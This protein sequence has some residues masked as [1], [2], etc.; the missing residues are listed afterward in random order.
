MPT[1]LRFRC[2]L[3]LFCAAVPC[4]QAADAPSGEQIYRKQC[5]S[6]H[7]DKGEGTK[8]FY[9]RPLEGDHSVA[10]LAKLIGKTMPKDDPGTCPD[11]DKVAAFVFDSFYSKAARERNQRP[12][13]ELSRLTVGQHQH[14]I[15]DLIAGFRT[16]GKW[17]DQHGLR[18]EYFS[19]RGFRTNQRVID[20]L[21]AEVRFDFKESSPEPE[22]IKPEEFAVRWQGSVLATE[23][24]DYEFILRS[25]NGCRLWVNDNNTPLI[26]A[27]VRSGTNIVERGSLHL[28]GGRAYPL[29]LEFFKSKEAKEKTAAIALEWK[30]PHGVAGP[31]PVKNLTPNHFPETLLLETAFPPDDRSLGWERGTAIS[32]AWDQ[33]ATD[34]ALETAAYVT[35][36]LGELSGARDGAA[37]RAAKLR[38]FC[39]RF[40]ERAFR[41]PL[42]AEQKRI[43]IDRQFE[44]A[45]DPETAVKR[46]VLLVL[47][48]PRFLYRE[49][50]GGSDAYDVA[51][52]L[53]FGLWDAPP[54][55][56]LLDAAAAG[57]LATREQVAKQ[58]E[59]MLADQRTH[60]KLHDFLIQWL[61][62][63]QAPEIAK[64]AER[65]PGFD[66]AIVADL[67]A[68]LNL[69][70]E[71]AVWAGDSDF[72]R[73]FLTDDLYLNGRL[74]KYYG[75]ELAAAAGF[76]KVK[77]NADQRA[78]ILTHP[79]LLA[80]FA[81]N[82]ASSPIHRGVFITRGVL[83]VTLRPPPDAFTPLAESLH[84]DLTTRE[85][86]TLQT[87]PASC[88]ACHGVINLLGFTLEHFDAVGRYRERDNGKAIDATGSYVTRNGDTLKF[89]G[90]RDLAKFLAGSDEVRGAFAEHLFQH[91]AKQPVAAYGPQKATDLRRSFEEHG[92]NVRKLLVEAVTDYA[93]PEKKVPSPSRPLRR[94]G[95]PVPPGG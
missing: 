42:T 71:D 54:D 39:G 95:K 63:D 24:G 94:S 65:F 55:R 61:K 67:R 89:D 86:V 93:L 7:G 41:R 58:A 80:A 19:A 77:L 45:S 56:E 21:D 75:V 87:K 92:N 23:T 35:A 50:A 51:S 9:A 70:L 14:A 81:Y 46:V 47:L 2:A 17:D 69:T 74:A 29:R 13:I 4:A 66:A 59:R 5:A 3:L 62:V 20:R 27:W 43:V 1:A 26:D 72:R 33:A 6:C 34:A 91:V 18:G 83:G 78:G 15:A 8:D 22:K 76:Q 53:A 11:A 64:D 48:S 85:R 79:Y 49:V 36:H 73:L 82:K 16:P 32:K 60:A 84:P 28:L 40:A 25:A 88:Q 31:I 57:K 30:P 52:R 44:K 38:D 10:Q 90:V 37:D 68:S 12:R